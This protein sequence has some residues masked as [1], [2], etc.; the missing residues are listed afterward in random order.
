MGDSIDNSILLEKA[1]E[2]LSGGVGIFELKGDKPAVKYMSRSFYKMFNVTEEQMKD[3]SN[4]YL[5]LAIPADRA[6]LKKQILETITTNKTT[7]RAIRFTD[8]N[9][10]G[11]FWVQVCLSVMSIKKGVI[12]LCAV[13]IDVTER[14]AQQLDSKAQTQM[15]RLIL[16]ESGESVFVY[17]V[18]ED[19]L[20]SQVMIDGE[21]VADKVY[22]HF[23]ANLDTQRIVHQED[24]KELFDTLTS[25]IVNE[26]ATE[27][28]DKVTLDVRLDL[29]EVGKY[30]W[31]RM[32]FLPL[33]N[34]EGKVCKIFGK[35]YSIN[36]EKLHNQELLLRAERDSLTGIYNHVTFQHKVTDMLSSFPGELCA[37][38][39]MDIDN[40]KHIND[41][42]GHY[43]GDDLLCDVAMNLED[44]ACSYGGFSGRLGGDEFALFVPILEEKVKAYEIADAIKYRLTEIKC[45][46]PHTM[47]IGISIH[48]IDADIT[49]D[50]VYREADQAL[51]VAKR[52][53]KNRYQEYLDELATGAK[54]S[55]VTTYSYNDDEGLV[56]DELEDVVYIADLNTYDLYYLNRAAKRTQ[57]IA[58][59]DDSYIEK[60]CYQLFMDRDEPCPFCT[61]SRLTTGMNVVSSHNNE[62]A[63]GFYVFKD[64]IIDWHGKKSRLEIAVDVSDADKVTAALAGSYGMEDAFA[65][66]LKIITSDMESST[67]Y[68]HLMEVLG[69]FY[70][71]KNACFVEYKENDGE[72]YYW[73][74]SGVES[75][76]SELLKLLKTS[77]IEEINRETSD[78]H[79]LILNRSNSLHFQNTEFAA[80][81]TECRIW[82]LYA[83]PVIV[84][85]QMLGRI[86]VFNP[87]R[88]NGDLR[89][90]KSISTFVGNDV[91]QIRLKEKEKYE[92]THDVQTKCLNRNSY[93]QLIRNRKE[94]NSLGIIIVDINETRGIAEMFGPDFS[95]RVI[96]DIIDKIKRIF[97]E[98]QIYRMGHDN[99]IVICQ[100]MEQL[101]FNAYAARLREQLLLG[102]FTACCGYVWN[103]SG[104]DIRRM[105][106]HASKLL[107]SEKQL[108]YE[109]N[110]HHSGKWSTIKTEMV[111]K[112][113]S[114]GYFSV[115]YQPKMV[116]PNGTICGAEALVRYSGNDDLA[117]VIDRLEKSNTIKYVDLFVLE[118]VCMDLSLWAKEGIAFLPVSCNFSR[119]SLIE[120]DI[121][122]KIAAVV[123]KYH[124]PHSL[125]E[126]E[127]TESVS[128]Q[129]HE[130]LKDVAKRIHELGF[131]IAMDDFGTKYS[132]VSILASLG[133]D[134]VKFDRSMIKDIDTNPVTV[135]VMS[136][137]I[138]MS[139]EL[140]MV[141]IAEGVENVTQA[142]VLQSLDLRNI[143]GYLCSKPLEKELY[144]DMCRKKGVS[145]VYV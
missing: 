93:I 16:Q 134:I 47:S 105:E 97:P 20:T 145:D 68:K 92:Y 106:D 144:I 73:K 23:G 65:S 91:Y 85:E 19:L 126:I 11:Y 83:V 103:D 109:N 27:D 116:Y 107:F 66:S 25:M 42:F 80:I 132:N 140:N 120:N 117:D 90:I 64:K 139:R 110:E 70:N 57:G 115:L 127:I 50:R 81:L 84:D 29:D 100:D 14:M 135:T 122:E 7:A 75:L 104:I 36:E 94:F 136:N 129:E 53:G 118:T 114:E 54:D 123:D 96:I 22:E 63:G 133:F 111:K 143:Q 86:F 34:S 72:L 89:L 30:E 141:C 101:M 69:S 6:V 52:N 121:A 4:N 142:N 67:K 125:V 60:K 3:Y 31:Y 41:A 15:L 49:F 2:S 28:N 137:L 33:K 77:V 95:D 128:E 82:S 74:S 99:F 56:F 112:E 43:A 45:E 58:E 113:L 32:L 9:T 46:L 119:V 35:Y 40:F 17:N 79:V 130:R 1:L 131:K 124:I 12:E 62:K 24:S 138:R 108:W 8:V 26:S 37:F 78:S 61:N 55:Y 88:H 102:E 44:I 76:E 5:T 59:C 71:S 87:E 38:Y 10:G 18:M 39:V 13:F 48:N 21:M 51:Y 98:E